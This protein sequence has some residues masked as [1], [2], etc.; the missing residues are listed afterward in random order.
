MIHYEQDKYY[1]SGQ[2][3]DV[4]VLNIVSNHIFVVEFSSNHKAY[5]LEVYTLSEM[6]EYF[7]LDGKGFNCDFMDNF[8]KDS[9]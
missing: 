5:S 6:R 1:L 7:P 4:Y 8:E 3:H 9:E 2:G